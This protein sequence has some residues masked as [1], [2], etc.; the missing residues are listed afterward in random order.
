MWLLGGKGLVH[1][2]NFSDILSISLSG[3][4]VN[5]RALIHWF[6]FSWGIVI[7]KQSGHILYQME[8]PFPTYISIQSK[9][10][11]C[12]LVQNIVTQ[13]TKLIENG[14]KAYIST[15]RCHYHGKLIGPTG[16]LSLISTHPAII[17]DAIML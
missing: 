9:I 17:L 15:K 4:K 10:T 3:F 11:K 5:A 6:T 14:Q 16:H 7:L 8:I 12:S 2:I 13:D 1:P